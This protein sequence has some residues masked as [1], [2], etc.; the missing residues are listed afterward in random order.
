MPTGGRGEEMFAKGIMMFFFLAAPLMYAIFG[1]I[2]GILAALVY[3][4][5]A[6]TTG[7]LCFTLRQEP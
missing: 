3:N 4:L 2:F 5:L 7:G 6:K 1:F